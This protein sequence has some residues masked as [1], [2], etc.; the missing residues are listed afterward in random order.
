MNHNRSQMKILIG[1]P[2]HEVK[3]YCMERWLQNVSGLTYPADLL[4][5]DNS[6]GTDY[7]EKV[8]SYCKKH[9]IK[10]YKLKHLELPPEQKVFERVARSREIIRQEILIFDYDAWFSWECD[11]IIP[12][13]TLD[14]L[15]RIMN[16]GN[17]TIVSHN[18]LTRENPDLPNFDFG[19]ALIKRE[20]LE[21]Y[22]FLLELGANPETPDTWEPSEEW[23]RKR[24]LKDGSSIIEVDGVI[25]PIYHLDE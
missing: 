4:M 8:K 5:V 15:V 10:K 23:F 16:T 13:N 25:K 3:N 14:E 24:I 21:R 18:N 12:S 6:P 22:G 20:A 9:G 19:V 2:I 11:Q 1:T 7:L 17:F